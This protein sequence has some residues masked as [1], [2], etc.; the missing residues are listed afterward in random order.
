[1]KWF[2]RVYT[3]ELGIKCNTD[4]TLHDRRNDDFELE[5]YPDWFPN[6]DIFAV[7]RDGYYYLCGPDLDALQTPLDVEIRAKAHLR[8]FFAIGSLLWDGLKKPKTGDVYEELPDGKLKAHIMF[9]GSMSARSKV[10]ATLDESSGLTMAQKYLKALSNETPHLIEALEFWATGDRSW[11]TLYKIDEAVGHHLHNAAAKSAIL[12]PAQ[13]KRFQH[14]ANN[15][16]AAGIN[17]RHATNKD[18]PPNNPMTLQEAQKYISNLLEKILN[19][20]N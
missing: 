4:G 20:V 6:G 9:S 12:D 11:F 2:V 7:K 10:K 13:R 17:A 1:M 19:K 8:R 15:A 3:D 18:E 5:N 14:T 16:K